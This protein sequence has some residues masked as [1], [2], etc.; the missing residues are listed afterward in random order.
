MTEDIGTHPPDDRSRPRHR[1]LRLSFESSLDILSVLRPAVGSIV[2]ALELDEQ[3]IFAAQLCVVEAV[4]NCVVHAYR[5]EA[6]R[7]ID[8]T[9]D[10]SVDLLVIEIR[11]QAPPAPK[12]WIQPPAPAT[13]EPEP[14]SEGG[15][16]IPLLHSLMDEVSVRREGESNVLRLSKE[17][18]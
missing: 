18:S 5:G 8:V 4:T 10:K 7:P 17:L 2:E 12:D 1:G 15:R 16:G 6:G 13:G 9:I 3:A 11:D 14:L